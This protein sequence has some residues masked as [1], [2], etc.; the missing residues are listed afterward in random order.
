MNYRRCSSPL[1]PW[2]ASIL[3][4]MALLTRLIMLGDRPVMHDE[5]MFA[6]NAYVFFESGRY[7]HLPI[8]HGPT[9]ML[10]SGTLFAIFGDSITVARA[11]IAV[12]SLVMLA[13]TLALVPRRYRLGFA[14]LLITSP[15]LLYY[16][17]FLRDDILFS[18]VLMVGMA[19][20]AVALSRRRRPGLIVRAACAALGMFMFVALAG[21]ME[22]AAFVYATGATFLLLLAVQRRLPRFF[23]GRQPAVHADA[24]TS[25]PASLPT[26]SPA[27]SPIRSPLAVQRSA[28]R[29]R[30]VLGTGWTGGLV[31]GLVLGLAYLAFV[32]GITLGPSFQDQARRA[33]AGDAPETLR[34]ISL[35]KLDLT[36]SQQSEVTVR[37]M[38]D[39]WRNVKESWDYWMGQHEQHRISGSSHYYLPILLTYEL[40]MCLLLVAGLI[41]DACLQKRRA[42][43]YGAACA[44]WAVLWLLWKLVSTN[45]APAWLAASERFLHLAPDASALTLGFLITPVLVWSILSLREH[46]VLAA[47]M[48]WWLACSVFQYSSAGEKVPWLATHIT[49]PLYLTVIWLWAPRLRRLRRLGRLGQMGRPG[50]TG[51]GAAVVVVMGIVAPFFV[52]GASLLALRNDIPLIGSRSADPA[53]RIVYNHTT[54]WLH[55]ALESRAALWN[56]MQDTVPL[57]QR[58]VVMTGDVVWPAVWYV[59]HFSYQFADEKQKLLSVPEGTDLIIGTAEQLAPL[60]EGAQAGRFMAHAGS[61]RDGWIQTSP[62]GEGG[63]DL[64]GSGMAKLWRYYW[65]REPWTARSR[66][67]VLVLEPMPARH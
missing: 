11:F 17:R 6:Y 37:L 3:V 34:A 64:L 20:L 12:A 44:S 7:T 8:L 42:A 33:V 1:W 32:Y 26:S 29:D 28:I 24:A 27:S 30:W 36:A 9:L 56:T 62:S 19:A 31:L 35:K 23:R 60:R 52:V 67:P 40:P 15:V 25:S 57:K 48:G 41:W 13:A 4:A 16:S 21:I 58:R 61:L 2:V 54:P 51:N 66:F 18:A 55:Q 53:E 39:S 5:S 59:R 22:N 63:L 43:V 49:L 46:R 14:P 38:A 65:T 10:A 45:V 50:R 47:W